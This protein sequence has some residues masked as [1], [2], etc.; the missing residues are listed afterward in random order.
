MKKKLGL[1]LWAAMAVSSVSTA[2]VAAAD[3][4]RQDAVAERG[5]D[6]MP[7]D[8]NATT[9]VFTKTK[10]GGVQQVVAK[11]ANDAAQIRLIREHLNEIAAQFS[12][13]DFSGPAS[14]H[15]DDMP[16]LA[17]LKK[18]A[19]AELK[20]QYRKMKAGARIIYTAHNPE[21]VAA[22]HKWFDAQVSDHGNHAME[23]HDHDHS[24]MH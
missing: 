23:G 24:G 10:T 14:I 7:F 1:L 12:K 16:G 5:V 2:S 20:V 19:P 4:A 21:L 9:H 3:T 22:L 13:R 11:S 18:A 15:G 6:V 17:E 8:L